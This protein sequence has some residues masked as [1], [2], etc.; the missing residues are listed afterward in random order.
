MIKKIIKILYRVVGATF[1]VAGIFYWICIVGIFDKELWRF[2]QMPF[3]WRLATA[4][5]AVLYPVTGLGLWL[6]TAW[7]LVLW[8]AV[9]GIDVAIYGAV[10]G[11]FGNSVMIGLHAVALLVVLLLWLAT[12]VTSRKLA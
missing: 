7:G 10:P 8:I 1:F 4:S 9:V 3:G 2:D 11:F 5:L 12:V 6:F